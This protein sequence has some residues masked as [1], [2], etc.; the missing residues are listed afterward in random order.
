MT[1][2]LIIFGMLFLGLAFAAITNNKPV[3]T[4]C[5]ALRFV[6]RNASDMPSK[7]NLNYI[8]ANID[9]QLPIRTE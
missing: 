3:K 7:E 9:K 4:N 6:E 2:T 5:A 8:A 1:K